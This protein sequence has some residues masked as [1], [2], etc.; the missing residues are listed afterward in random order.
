MAKI[1][2]KFSI[3]LTL[4]LSSLLLGYFSPAYADLSSGLVAHWSFNDCTANDTS[5]KANHGTKLTAQ[6]CVPGLYG[7]D[8]ALN[9]NG[10]N[11]WIS[12]RHSSSLNITNKLSITTWIKFNHFNTDQTIVGKIDTSANYYGFGLFIGNKILR[13]AHATGNGWAPYSSNITEY[14]WSDVKENQ[15]Y[16][17]VATYDGANAKI[18][19]DGN[20]VANFP[21]TG[22]VTNTKNLYIGHLDNTLRYLNADIANMRIYN[23]ALTDEDVM[24]LYQQSTGNILGGFLDLDNSSFDYQ[25]N[26]IKLKFVV[27][28]EK[29]SNYFGRIGFFVNNT[30]LTGYMGVNTVKS[31]LGSSNDTLVLTMPNNVLSSAA[32]ANQRIFVYFEKWMH[33]DQLNTDAWLRRFSL[34]G[35]TDKV[36]LFASNA[37]LN[38]RTIVNTKPTNELVC[39]NKKNIQSKCNNF[40]ASTEIANPSEQSGGRGTTSRDTYTHRLLDFDKIASA[41]N[42]NGKWTNTAYGQATLNDNGRTPLLLIHGWQ[43]DNGLR[44]PAKLGL[45]KYSELQYWRHF[46]DYYLATPALQQ[47]YHVYLYHYTTYKHVT[48]NAKILTEMLQELKTNQPTSDL[49]AVMQSGGKGVVVLAHSMGGLVARS[50]IEEY[51]AFGANAEKLRRLITLDT[52]HHGSPAANPNWKGDIPKDLYT[53]GSADIQWDNFDYLYGSTAVNNRKTERNNVNNIN[54]KDFD[55]AYQSACSGIT[56]CPAYTQNPWLAGLNVN[57]IPHM[58]T[59]NS[60]YLLYSG[61][62]IN[63]AG[64]DPN[65]VIVNNGLMKYSDDQLVGIAKIPSGGAEPV[66]SSLWYTNSSASSTMP[67]KLESG[68]QNQSPFYTFKSLV[69]Y[70]TQKS[71]WDKTQWFG[72]DSSAIQVRQ[73]VNLNPVKACGNSILISKSTYLSDFNYNHPLGFQLRVFWDYNH[74]NMVNGAYLLGLGAWDKYINTSYFLG[75]KDNTT[76]GFIQSKADLSTGNLVRNIYIAKA[77]GYLSNDEAYSYTGSIN[78][79]NPLQTEPLF[80]VLQRDLEREA[81]DLSFIVP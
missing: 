55:A 65:E 69:S 79:F 28:P 19:I 53:Q 31:T 18:Y 33:F 43:G 2:S 46:L 22:N 32:N 17:I 29:L 45:W 60:K 26:K 76:S 7:A 11:N 13:F 27:P 44:N 15:W 54:S 49:T 73:F 34:D 10:T 25:N 52:P 47:K 56:T 71:N 62:M 81:S 39:T 20:L 41:I 72:G 35:V 78:N 38:S 68:G 77:L 75:T 42:L 16:L 30:Q 74:E 6:K 4:F 58:N 37:V 63:L 14:N 40:F 9:F 3:A 57:F 48:Y 8:K 36:R 51:D 23:R 61:W 21:V 80:L 24:L 1:K 12:V 70:C 50:A 64:S 67:F 59:Y 5:G 66:T